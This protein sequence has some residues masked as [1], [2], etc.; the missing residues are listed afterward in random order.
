MD[1]HGWRHVTSLAAHALQI[2]ALLSLEMAGLQSRGVGNM[3]GAC[4][5]IH[6]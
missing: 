5:V 6:M 1:Y 3:F 4:M 2:F